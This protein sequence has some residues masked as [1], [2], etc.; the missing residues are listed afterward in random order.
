MKV[1]RFLKLKVS[2]SIVLIVMSQ[3]L[4]ALYKAKPQQIKLSILAPEGSTWM[5]MMHEFNKELKERTNGKLEFKIYAGGVS[6]DESDVIRKM[7][8]GQIHAGG[9]TGVGLGQIVSDVRVLELPFIF[10]EADEVDFV[11]SVLKEEFEKKFEKKGFIF[12]GWAEAGFVNIFSTKPLKTAKDLQKAKM[13]AWEGDPLVKALCKEFDIVPVPLSITDV[14]TSL[15]TGLIDSFYAPPLAA[16]ALQWFTK[17]K[18]MTQPYLANATGAMVMTKKFYDQIPKQ[19]QQILKEVADKYS[20]RIIEATRKDN[21]ESYHQL[22]KQGIEFVTIAP[23][24]LEKMTK[25]SAKVQTALI[26]RL[27][28]K[29]LLEKV[30]SKIREYRKSKV[31]S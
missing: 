15:Q 23:N 5:N 19:N 8:V 28:P 27:Y 6:G 26:G 10:R 9:F 1:K 13:W 18:Y 30:L 16:I 24:E 14:L 31:Q 20:K 25:T 22:K 3:D 2:L 12:L 11:T 29:E 7:R 17:V 4:L 21:H